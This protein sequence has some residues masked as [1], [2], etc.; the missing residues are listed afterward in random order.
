MT[1]LFNV[2]SILTGIIWFYLLY[3]LLNENYSVFFWWSSNRTLFFY[4][5]H[6]LILLAT[7]FFILG[8]LLNLFNLIKSDKLNNTLLFSNLTLIILTIPHVCYF[9]YASFHIGIASASFYQLLLS[10]SLLF[11]A[12]T[13]LFSTLLMRTKP[14]D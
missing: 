4:P 10:T 2:I 13:N 12:V 9:A 14:Q 8:N 3:N 5:L 1:K 11:I 7:A 6:Y